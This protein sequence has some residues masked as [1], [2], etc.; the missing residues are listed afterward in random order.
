MQ[1]CTNAYLASRAIEDTISSNLEEPFA[2]LLTSGHVSEV[3]L[4]R[5]ALEEVSAHR[6]RVCILPAS[7]YPAILRF[8]EDWREM[9]ADFSFFFLATTNGPP[10]NGVLLWQVV[11]AWESRGWVLEDYDAVGQGN[12]HVV[13]LALGLESALNSFYQ[14]RPQFLW[15]CV[16]NRAGTIFCGAVWHSIAWLYNGFCKFGGAA[17]DQ[18]ETRSRRCS[19]SNCGLST[20]NH[21]SNWFPIFIFNTH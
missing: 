7:S 6:W 12:G 13:G 1:R 17:H 16:G 5:V 11:T 10:R 3:E 2:F 18:A 15:N 19:K 4:H 8:W 20:Q 14:W 9:S 21:S